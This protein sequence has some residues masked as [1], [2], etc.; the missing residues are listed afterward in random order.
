MQLAASI[1]KAYDIRGVVPDTLN[2]AVAEA[3]GL[4]FGTQALQQGEHTVAVGRDGRLSGPALSAALI[5]GLAAAGVDVIDIGMVTTPMLYFAAH[6]LCTS[7]IQVTGSH[8]PKDYNGFKMVLGGRAIYGDDIQALR[9][10]MEVENW[11]RLDGGRVREVNVGPAYHDRIVSDVKLQRPMRVVIDCGNGVAGASAP[12]L[13]RALGCEV[14]EL[15]S[16]VDG[17][18]PNHHPDPS[19]PENLQDVI[20]TLR[21]TGA[22]LGLAFD[23][24][25]D[26]LGIVTR[27]G[28]NIYPDRQMI[29]FARDVLSRVPGGNILFDVKCSQRLAPAIEAAGG[30]A[31]IYKTGHSLI[32]ARMKEL[33]SPLGGEMSG[34]IFF[35]ERWYGFDDGTYAGAR[36]LEILSRSPDANAVL[37]ALPTSFSTPELNVAC[38][39]GEPHTVVAQLV[40]LARF[41]APAKISTIDGVRV[42]WPDGFGLIRASNT[43]PV[44]VMRFEGH[45]PEAL[46]RIEASMLT[47]LRQAKPDAVVG[48]SAH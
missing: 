22:E 20:R 36:L 26:R 43:T 33:D 1:F 25:G 15:F 42:D 4:A 41:D 13:F 3:L 37:D 32:K 2:E 7:G 19:K 38:A 28:N 34:H 48:A 12:A 44:L 39:E 9:R 29:L 16:E 6:T 5:R 47:L 18:F 35:K 8:N 21:E 14:I 27:G 31:H 46:H 10:M 17:N 11:Q 24:D 30:V 45:T 40:E 23:G